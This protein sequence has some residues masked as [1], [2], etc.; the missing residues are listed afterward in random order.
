MHI[1][2]D[3]Q[4]KYTQM[5]WKCF[6]SLKSRYGPE[7]IEKGIFKLDGLVKTDS[8]TRNNNRTSNDRIE[9]IENR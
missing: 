8:K 9:T 6:F 5:T 7:L 4:C 3:D 2:I 1:A